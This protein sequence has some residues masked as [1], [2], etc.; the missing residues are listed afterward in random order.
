M[1]HMHIIGE[2]H[3]SPCFVYYLVCRA[4]W[5]AFTGVEDGTLAYAIDVTF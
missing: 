5:T 1:I 2:V 3:R 4:V